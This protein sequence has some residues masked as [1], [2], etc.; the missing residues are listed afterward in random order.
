LRTPANSLDWRYDAAINNLDVQ[1]IATPAEVK[2]GLIAFA[3]AAGICF[4]S[5][6]FAVDRRGQWWFLE[7]NEQGQFLWLEQYSPQAALLQ[8]FCAFLTAN[9]DA[10]ELLQDRQE[11]FPSYLDYDR[12]H[13][14]RETMDFRTATADAPFKSV[15]P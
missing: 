6:D 8:K 5:A 3:E 14:N 7:I 12:A 15:E 10:G 2:D 1:I 13:P 11:L 9:E 4:G